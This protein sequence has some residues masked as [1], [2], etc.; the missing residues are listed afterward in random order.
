MEG[1]ASGFPYA[2][3]ITAGVGVNRYRIVPDSLTTRDPGQAGVVAVE[4][5]S[6]EKAIKVLLLGA[7]F[8]TQ[9][10]G[11]GALASGS[12]RCLGSPGRTVSL[13]LLDYGTE[14]AVQTLDED[15]ATVTVPVVAMRFSKK[16][17]LPNNIVVLLA[18][19]MLLRLS[20]L[21]RMRAWIITR[22]NCLRRICAADLIAAI[23]GGDSFSDIYGLGRFFYVSLPLILALLLR[24]NLVLLPQTLGPFAGK[25]PRATARWIMRR[26]QRVYSRDR[27]GLD[28]LKALLGSAYDA[29]KHAF[30]YDV[31]FV[32]E[33]REPSQAEIVGISSETLSS[34]VLV[35]LN[36]SGLL[37]AGGYTHD[38]M[39]GLCADYRKVVY[40]VVDDLIR[41]K[42]AVVLLVPHVF[43]LKPGSESDILAC[44]EVFGQ[45]S[46]QYDGRL[47]LVK[48][49]FDQSSIKYVIGKCDFFIGSRMHACI[50]ALS[51]E[52]PAVS[53][54][55]SRKFVGVLDT[56]G[57]STLVADARTMNAEQIIGVINTAFDDR[58]RLAEHLH[59]TMP[60]VKA[61]ILRLSDDIFGQPQTAQRHSIS[62]VPNRP[63][64]SIL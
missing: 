64:P 38:N 27:R 23:S 12:L 2:D 52:V 49:V 4:N 21:P 37:L 51:Q 36:V 34:S 5:M 6:E 28:E 42:N 63:V 16:V 9:N 24:K 56:I 55:Y 25:V 54:A 7:T 17:Y 44:E 58:E 59:K 45:L 20:P 46:R 31:G 29:K 50:A 1:K 61:T 19:A 33:P 15:G 8:N 53:V 30:C 11:V 41:K 57:V 40:A 3:E 48:G 32:L 10:M 13:S 14:E 62:A 39:F 26:A 18:L 47:G 60:A 35:G 22:N 43:G